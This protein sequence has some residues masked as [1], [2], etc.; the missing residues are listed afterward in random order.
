MLTPR[1]TW[2]MFWLNCNSTTWL[3]LT[4]PRQ[5]IPLMKPSD[6][7]LGLISSRTKRSYGLFSSSER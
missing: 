2:E 3:A 1:N 7:A 5:R 6:S 4:T